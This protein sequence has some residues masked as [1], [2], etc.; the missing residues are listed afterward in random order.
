MRVCVCVFLLYGEGEVRSAVISTPPRFGITFS[1]R[2]PVSVPSMM[3]ALEI[4]NG[5]TSLDVM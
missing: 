2:L 1:L 3:L 5:W 4:I